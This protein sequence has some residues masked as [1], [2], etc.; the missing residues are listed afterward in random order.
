MKKNDTS[1]TNFNE[2]T[3]CKLEKYLLEQYNFRYNEVTK[4]T[5]FKPKNDKRAF[6]G[7]DCKIL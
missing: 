6:G 7:L 4:E 5:E 2:S 1:S 3:V